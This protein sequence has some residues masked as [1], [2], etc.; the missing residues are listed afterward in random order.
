MSIL[1]G[2]A[3]EY[4][5]HTS[6]FSVLVALRRSSTDHICPLKSYPSRVK[7][8]TVGLASASN[9]EY[10]SVAAV[11]LEMSTQAPSCLI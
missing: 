11:A 6:P 3:E 10:P 1:T 5:T 8:F 7:S 9:P 4:A 2:T